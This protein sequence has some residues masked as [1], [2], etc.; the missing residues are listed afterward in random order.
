MI[1]R[2]AGVFA[3]VALLGAAA[4][5]ATP[6]GRLPLALRGLSRVLGRPDGGK[7]GGT[8]PAWRKVFAFLLVVLA[9]LLAMLLHWPLNFAYYFTPCA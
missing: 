5:F 9:A 8:V 4:A 1:A 6:R 3:V 7:N 2:I